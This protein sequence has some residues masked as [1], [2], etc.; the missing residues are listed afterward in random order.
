M[1]PRGIFKTHPVNCF[2]CC[3]S[4]PTERLPAHYPVTR[5][6]QALGEE[7]DVGERREHELELS[8]SFVV[9]FLLP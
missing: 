8:T 4:L 6:L 9:G 7:V 2:G 5:L 1:S 3:T